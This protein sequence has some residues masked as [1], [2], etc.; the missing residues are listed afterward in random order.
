MASFEDS[1]RY[2]CYPDQRTPVMTRSALLLCALVVAG[3]PSLAGAQA[4]TTCAVGQTVTDREDKTGVIVSGSNKLCQVE[5][6]DGQVYGWIYW[7]LRPAAAPPASASSPPAAA[8]PSGHNAP[9]PTVLR[10]APSAH[11]LVYRT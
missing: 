9:A 1:D 2:F 10:T 4:L 11:T 6:P 8:D 5:Y 3:A 7:N